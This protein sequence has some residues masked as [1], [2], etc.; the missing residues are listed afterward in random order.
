MDNNIVQFI[1]P[2]KVCTFCGRNES[3]VKSM[4]ASQVTNACICGECIKHAKQRLVDSS[5][6]T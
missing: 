2:L 4:I 6:A 3:Q 5:T 1:K